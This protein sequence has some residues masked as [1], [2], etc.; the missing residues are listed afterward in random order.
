MDDRIEV[1]KK[2]KRVGS[3]IFI[4]VNI[5]VVV[6]L[7]TFE[8][9]GLTV[10]ALKDVASL[11]IVNWPYFLI[12]LASPLIILFAETLKYVLLI[13]TATGRIRFGL[14]WKTAV[15]G[16]YYDNVTPLGSGGQAFQMVCLH[17]GGVSQGV[18]GSLPI[19]GFFFMQLA[20][21]VIGVTV[22][23]FNG[24]VIQSTVIRVLAWIGLAFSFVFP[25]TFL[26]LSLMPRFAGK[27]IRFVVNCLVRL[28][29]VKNSEK[30]EHKINQTIADYSGS[31]AIVKN[32]TGTMILSFFLS[33][34]YQIVLCS[35][36]YFVVKACGVD[37]PW[38]DMFSLCVFTYAAIGIV[39]TPGNSGAAELSFAFIFTV[40]S[41]GYL[42]WGMV[43]WRFSSYYMLL[44][45]G[46]IMM[47]I[48]RWAK[49]RA[50]KQNR[51]GL[52]A[53]NSIPIME[54]EHPSDS[55]GTSNS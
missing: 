2:R 38:V 44:I 54:E 26:I 43:L 46:L 27:T 37:A 41:H 23:V 13:R 1:P 55:P 7:G 42:L 3:F 45:L 28:K 49:M 24:D 11:W 31:M 12:V 16:K 8:F 34:A 33:I 40:L 14:A 15:Y 10:I 32:A 6:I 25:L 22:F 17:Q 4:L 9:R 36:P 21:F 47:M 52:D 5:V 29:I 53:A 48:D 18:S 51:I 30:L 39:P 19:F 50:E 20:F 35:I